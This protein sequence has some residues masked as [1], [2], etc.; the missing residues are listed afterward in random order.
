M[1][2]LSENKAS[3][4]RTPYSFSSIAGARPRSVHVHQ[5][6]MDS[7]IYAHNHNV[8]ETSLILSSSRLPLNIL[9]TE[10]SHECAIPRVFSY[11]YGL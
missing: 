7:V 5:H 8:V 1:D 10:R 11:A 2:G 9:Y 3:D 4:L 6:L